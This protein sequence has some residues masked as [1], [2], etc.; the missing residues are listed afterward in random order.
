MDSACVNWW[1]FPHGLVN[2]LKCF[3]KRNFSLYR[4]NYLPCGGPSLDG[5]VSDIEDTQWG[6]VGGEDTG[7]A[8]GKYGYRVS[9]V[10]GS[11]LIGIA[12]GDMFL[13]GPVEP[14]HIV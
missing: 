3:N 2:L 12:D 5:V 6:E 7:G 13:S 4:L 14:V 9:T 1:D 8:F 10:D 11:I